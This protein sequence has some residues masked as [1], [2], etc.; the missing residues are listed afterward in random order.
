MKHPTPQ[1]SLLPARPRT[2]LGLPELGSTSRGGVSPH[3]HHMQRPGER[4]SQHQLGADG[5]GAGGRRLAPTSVTGAPASWEGGAGRELG[6]AGVAAPGAAHATALHRLQC[7]SLH[8]RA[9]APCPPPQEKHAPPGTSLAADAAGR[10]KKKKKTNDLHPSGGL[11][12][13]IAA[14]D[15]SGWVCP[16][17]PRAVPTG[18][19]CRLRARAAV[20]RCR[21]RYR[22][23]AGPFLSRKHPRKRFPSCTRRSP[24]YT[25]L[26]GVSFPGAPGE[27]C[28]NPTWELPPWSTENRAPPIPPSLSFS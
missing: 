24:G 17:T 23:A 16:A 19:V 2:A 6:R 27:L 14:T 9:A 26:W 13:A 10:K 8:P 15:S 1:S 4:S 7:A 3:R 11:E 21:C 18:R 5:P 22:A 25:Q 28:S 12:I 20:R